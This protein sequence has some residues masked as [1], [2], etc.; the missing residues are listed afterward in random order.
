[1][2]GRFFYAETVDSTS[3]WAKRFIGKLPDS[4]PY[5]FIA[6]EQSQGRGVLNRSFFSPRDGGLYFTLLW[7][8]SYDAEIAKF[9]PHRGALAT[10]EVLQSYGIDARLKWVNDV[11]LEENER[12]IAGILTES[13]LST[14]PWWS[15]GIGINLCSEG[16]G[17]PEELLHVVDYI[18]ESTEEIPVDLPESIP[19][20]IWQ[21]FYKL[22]QVPNTDLLKQYQIHQI[23]K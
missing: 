20:K 16:V 21:T 1:M 13:R 2:E 6:R 8:A 9:L 7:K 22:L 18:Y 11:L 23:Q 4:G 14:T 3:N 10:C 17:I 19:M 15:L 12:K 5:L